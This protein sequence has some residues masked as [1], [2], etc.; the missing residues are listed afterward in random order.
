VAAGARPVIAFVIDS[1]SSGGA[2]RQLVELA[3]ALKRRGRFEPVVFVYYDH[4]FFAPRLREAG[5]PIVIVERSGSRDPGFPIR[6]RMALRAHN[7]SLVHAFLFT[8]A[9]W[10]WLAT[11]L[12]RSRRP[13]LVPAQRDSF[14][15][16]TWMER[17]LQRLVYR[18]SEFVTTNAEPVAQLLET[19]IG[20][21]RERVRYLP[22]GIDLARW[23]TAQNDACPLPLEPGR[24][25]IGL[26]GGLRP[27]KN[28]ALLFRA[29]AR[30]PEALRQ[31]WRVWCV[32]DESSGSEAARR[33]RSEVEGSALADIVRIEPAVANVS[34]L[35]ARLD[36][37]VLTSTHEGFP[38]V[39]LEAQASALPVISTRVGD[40]AN[41]VEDG[42]S[43][44]LVGFDER[45]IATALERLA[46]DPALRA[47]LG[48]RGRAIV[49]S[50]YAME[51]V[52]SLYE[53]FYEESLATDGSAAQERA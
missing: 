32:G 6:L 42:V 20:V 1:L 7:V 18:S 5:V 14:V 10:A 17:Q 33:I 30:V 8:P 39:L 45:E 29:L 16:R 34:A 38:N 15:A 40:V 46:S 11:R 53:A 48:K 41:L 21:A 27:Q 35:F 44:F 9:C 23:D 12:M 50:R 36:A 31:D 51:R 4:A 3:V 22:N 25:H 19:E 28:H 13:T 43:G 52:A 37:V 24:F 47:R 26:I 2:Q 49:E